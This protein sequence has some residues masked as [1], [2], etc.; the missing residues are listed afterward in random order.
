M[1]AATVRACSSAFGTDS[2]RTFRRKK[3]VPGMGG[4]IADGENIGII[5]AG[6][7]INENPSHRQSGPACSAS[8]VLGARPIPT[9][10]KS[11]GMDRS[12]PHRTAP[13]SLPSG[14]RA[15]SAHG[16]AGEDFDAGFAME[17]ARRKLTARARSPSRARR[18]AP[19]S[20]VVLRPRL[21][22]TAAT[23]RPT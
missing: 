21:M 15:K 5:G 23:S 2:S 7:I 8:S 13:T 18:G 1:T 19:S 10:T 22:A 4:T 3:P 12:S 17:I 20:T 6:A 14:P 11:A 16:D 9:R